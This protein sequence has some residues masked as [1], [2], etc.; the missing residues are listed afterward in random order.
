MQSPCQPPVEL[1]MKLIP[2]SNISFSTKQLAQLQTMIDGALARMAPA[3]P[4]NPP[5]APASIDPA[6]HN[7]HG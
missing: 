4:A 1:V 3:P 5:I 7:W 2:N 6:N